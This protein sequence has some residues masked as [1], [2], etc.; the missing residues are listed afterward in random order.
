M[1]PRWNHQH[2]EGDHR[3]EKSNFVE[4]SSKHHPASLERNSLVTI[5]CQYVFDCL[6]VTPIQLEHHWKVKLDSII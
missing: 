3:R 1:A 4:R 5:V 6:T 2:Y